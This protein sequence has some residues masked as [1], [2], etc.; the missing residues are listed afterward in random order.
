MAVSEEQL[1]CSRCQKT[2]AIDGRFWWYQPDGSIADTSYADL[3][4]DER[5]RDPKSEFFHHGC[6]GRLEPLARAHAKGAPD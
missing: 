3:E 1:R 6:L 2:I 5:I 4:N